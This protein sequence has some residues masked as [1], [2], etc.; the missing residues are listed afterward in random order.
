MLSRTGRGGAFQSI[1]ITYM[2]DLGN[3]KVDSVNTLSRKYSSTSA[4]CLVQKNGFSKLKTDDATFIPK[5]L[6]SN[7]SVGLTVKGLGLK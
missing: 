2:A 7:I 5:L 3:R 1:F 4:S 6:L